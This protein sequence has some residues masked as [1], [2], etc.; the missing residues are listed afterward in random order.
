MSHE[1]TMK[2]ASSLRLLT[3]LINELQETAAQIPDG[4]LSRE[5][6]GSRELARDIRGMLGTLRRTP[7]TS[8]IRSIQKL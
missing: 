2:V 3:Q 6:R 5:I 1:E 4:K 7:E 8:V